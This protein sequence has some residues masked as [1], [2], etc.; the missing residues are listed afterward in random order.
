[1]KY[2]FAMFSIL[3]GTFIYIYEDQKP[4][5]NDTQCELIANQ[6]KLSISVRVSN[7][8]QML[9][10]IDNCNL[11]NKVVAFYKNNNYLGSYIG[12]ATK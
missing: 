4:N 7:A 11:N 8:T 3:I 12:H 10:I 6:D 5:F 1:M 2:V 9:D